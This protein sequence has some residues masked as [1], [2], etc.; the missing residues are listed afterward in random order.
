MLT[1]HSKRQRK[2]LTLL[3][4]CNSDQHF[5]KLWYLNMP[6][7]VILWSPPCLFCVFGIHQERNYHDGSSRSTRPITVHERTH[8]YMQEPTTT[9]YKKPSGFLQVGAEQAFGRWF[10]HRLYRGLAHLQRR[11]LQRRPGLSMCVRKHFSLISCS[12][13]SRK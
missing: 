12:L 7:Q 13:A 1:E 10:V 11:H 3:C 4:V 8:I 5:S 6:L 2:Y 9:F